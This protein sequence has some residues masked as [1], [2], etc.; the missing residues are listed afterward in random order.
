M[1]SYLADANDVFRDI[2]IAE[3]DKDPTQARILLKRA[4]LDFYGSIT[5]L[6]CGCSNEP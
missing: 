6:W 1:Y 3:L 2:N 4:S 5:Y